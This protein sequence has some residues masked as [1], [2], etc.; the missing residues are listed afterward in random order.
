MAKSS[1]RGR[2]YFAWHTNEIPINYGPWKF[3][4][5]GG[6]ILEAYDDTN[7]FHVSAL[8]IK[9]I[10]NNEIKDSLDNVYEQFIR[11]EEVMSIEDLKLYID[12]KNKI[13]LNRI[14]QQLPR[15]YSPPE[16]S[17]D[18]KDCDESLEVY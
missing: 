17:K 16:I 7:T 18:C 1:F 15:G 10:S 4:N 14:K 13:I 6:L 9:Q 12:N 3:K 5:L 8:N 11:N 2:N